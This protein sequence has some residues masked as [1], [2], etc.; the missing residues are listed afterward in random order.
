MLYV[1]F[2]LFVSFVLDDVSFVLHVCF[3][4]VELYVSCV[5]YDVSRSVRH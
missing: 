4:L 3:V 1:S 2:V 5:L